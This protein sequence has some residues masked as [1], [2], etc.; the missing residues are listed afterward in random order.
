M[1]DV[2][3]GRALAG[4]CCVSLKLVSAQLR[5]PARPPGRVRTVLIALTKSRFIPMGSDTS[6]QQLDSFILLLLL[7]YPSHVDR[8]TE[9]AR[10]LIICPTLVARVTMF[11]FQS[12]IAVYS[13]ATEYVINVPI[14]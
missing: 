13:T 6:S 1:R 3:R 5:E 4:L 7:Q 8:V 11:V 9:Q 12:V 14:I 10:R 2:L